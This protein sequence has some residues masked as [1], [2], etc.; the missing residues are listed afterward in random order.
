M[1]LINCPSC[2]NQVSDKA[3]ACIKCGASLQKSLKCSECGASFFISLEQCPECGCPKNFIQTK[4][5]DPQ[6]LLGDPPSYNAQTDLQAGEHPAACQEKLIRNINYA[7][8]WRRAAALIIDIIISTI[9]TYLIVLCLLV[10]NYMVGFQ[11]PDE[12][13]VIARLVNLWYGLII[14]FGV[15]Y[16][17]LMESSSK[18]ATIG[19]LV[20]GIKV[21]DLEGRRISFWKALGRYVS[22]SISATVLFAGYIMV[23]YDKQKRGLHDII[24]STLV[25][26]DIQ[27]L[28]TTPL[29][30]QFG[31]HK[32][33]QWI[34]RVFEHQPVMNAEQ[35]KLADSGATEKSECDTNKTPFWDT[36]MVSLSAAVLLL[37]VIV[38]IYVYRVKEADKLRQITAVAEQQRLKQELAE[39]AA[40]DQ[41]AL[42]QAWRDAAKRR[43]AENRLAQETAARIAAE[44]DLTTQMDNTAYQTALR[45]N[46][47][48]AYEQYLQQYPDGRHI[49]DVQDKKT[50]LE[51]AV[52]RQV[53]TQREVAARI[54]A[55]EQA[56]REAAARTPQS[57]LIEGIQL[58][59]IPAGSF[60]MGSN[61]G[62]EDEKPLHQVSVDAFYIGKY[63]ITEMQWRSVMGIGS[64]RVGWPKTKV[65]WDDASVFCRNLSY[66]TGKNFRLPTEAEWE[67]ACRAR[68]SNDMVSDPA[69]FAWYSSNSRGELHQIGQLAPNSWGVYDMLGNLWE[70]CADYY[71]SNYYRQSPV[72]NP[73]G[74]TA[75]RYRVLRGGS[76]R[77]DAIDIRAANR[78]KY[79]MNY[80]GGDYGFR[81][82]LGP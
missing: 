4:I 47:I 46:T 50:T 80:G 37:V 82:V 43:T 75:G 67:Y 15:F 22:K 74:P 61:D 81:C 55:A 29:F 79:S 24:A 35:Q 14:L 64:N 41:M 77:D 9:G 44:N 5:P 3:E 66:K 19:K 68:S 49:Q 57:L 20:L 10:V 58:V 2:G 40:A 12:P 7:G 51:E 38:S 78:S 26:K 52:E 59:L 73:Y 72:S 34:Q 60:A 21:T 71:D 36:N 25:V 23:A 1:A 16:Y 45:T 76:W 54:A 33:T 63:E 6:I 30:N 48:V 13:D 69:K 53:A 39:K 8:F 42:D 70:W 18:Q 28:K 17:P 65:S 62:A 56:A 31:W 27:G 11:H 32:I